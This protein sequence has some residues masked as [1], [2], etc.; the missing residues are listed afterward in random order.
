MSRKDSRKP[1]RPSRKSRRPSVG[2]LIK[3]AKA[4]GMTITSVITTTEGV[5]LHFGEPAKDAPGNI[6]EQL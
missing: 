5:T 3:Q 6:L 2:P 1:R 4:A